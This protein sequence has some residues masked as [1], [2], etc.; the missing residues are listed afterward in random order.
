HT[1]RL[2]Q[3]RRG[4]RTFRTTRIAAERSAA[5]CHRRTQRQLPPT[6]TAARGCRSRG[7]HRFG[8]RERDAGRGRAVVGGEAAGGRAGDV[9]A[10]AATPGC[11]PAAALT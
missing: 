8:R 3:R 11:I 1:A 5:L 7:S 9:E 4:G 10:L 2:S 6:R